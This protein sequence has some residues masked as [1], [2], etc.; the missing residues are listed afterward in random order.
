[1]LADAAGVLEP[2]QRART[3]TPGPGRTRSAG[4]T[5]PA[6]KS[7]GVALTPARWI[8]W[9]VLSS[10]VAV[11]MIADLIAIGD[12]VGFFDRSSSAM[13]ATCGLDIEVPDSAS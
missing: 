9:P 13:P 1:M 6:P 3:R 5:C 12:Q 10:V 8:G 7:S 11:V 4:R 2:L